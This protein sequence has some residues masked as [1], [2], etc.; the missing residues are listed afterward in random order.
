MQCSAQQ[1]IYIT[2][3]YVYVPQTFGR[4]LQINYR[5]IMFQMR[6]Q[7]PDV[8]FGAKVRSTACSFH[9]TLTFLLFNN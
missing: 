1:E 6:L 4:K 3:K 9:S 5:P 7:N 2:L 8:C